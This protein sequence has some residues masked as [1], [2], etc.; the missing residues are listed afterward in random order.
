MKI[1][2]KKRYKIIKE[3]IIKKKM[4]VFANF[5]HNLKSEEVIRQR[6]KISELFYILSFN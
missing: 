3:N 6:M 5:E 4:K 1:I 2:L